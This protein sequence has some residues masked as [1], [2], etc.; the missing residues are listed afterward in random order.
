MTI[1]FELKK[2]WCFLSNVIQS[3]NGKHDYLMV[4]SWLVDSLHEFYFTTV[5][6]FIPD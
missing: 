6:S 2:K 4:D 3:E 1:Q 5:K